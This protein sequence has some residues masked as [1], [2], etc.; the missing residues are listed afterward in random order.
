MVLAHR[1]TT[2]TLQAPLSNRR[3]LGLRRGPSYCKGSRTAPFSRDEGLPSPAP[4]RRFSRCLCFCVCK[5][6]SVEAGTFHPAH[7][8]RRRNSIPGSEVIMA[9]EEAFQTGGL[10]SKCRRGESSF[11]QELQKPADLEARRM[12]EGDGALLESPPPLKGEIQTN[13]KEP[14]SKLTSRNGPQ[15]SLPGSTLFQ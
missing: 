7:S 1:K 9:E 14:C 3:E 11:P 5:L 10:F 12:I 8:F 2:I 13:L 15:A 6:E 4:Q